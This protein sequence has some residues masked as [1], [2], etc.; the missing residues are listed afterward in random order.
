[1]SYTSSQDNVGS[2]AGQYQFSDVVTGLTP[3]TTY[4][5][6]MVATNQYGT[7]EGE[8]RSC[9]TKNNTVV[10]NEP[11]A[12]ITRTVVRQTQVT[13]IVTTVVA[14]SKNNC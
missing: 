11:S 8:I 7:K 10:I 2:N 9:R 14:R 4:Y 12:P 5:Y 1:L 13:P 3:N 6:K